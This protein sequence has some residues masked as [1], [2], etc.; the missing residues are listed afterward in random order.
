MPAPA[1]PL[2]LLFSF[3][4]GRGHLGPL[5]PLARTAT[6]AG[7]TTA[8]VGVRDV[9]LEQTAFTRLHPRDLPAFADSLAGR[10]GSGAGTRT[11]SG[12]RTGGTGTLLPVDPAKV[13]QRVAAIFLGE[14][15]EVARD[16]VAELLRQDRVD[17]LVCDGQDFG[18]MVAAERAGVPV[19][20]VDVL[21]TA[22]DEWVGSIRE[23][24]GRLRADSGL[25]PGSGL[26]RI[27]GDLAVV[28]FP[29]CLRATEDGDGPVVRMRPEPPEPGRDHPALAWLAAG[30][31]ERRVYVTLGTAFA[32]A[33]GDLLPRILAGLT[34]LPCRVLV[35]TGPGLDPAAVAVASERV[36]VERHVP[37]DGVLELVDLAVTH[38]GSGSVMGALARAVPVL[39]LPLG[40]DQLP[41][42]RRVA[43]LGCGALLDAATA[44]PADIGREASR[45][46]ASEAVRRSAERVRRECESLPPVDE[47]LRRIE[48]LA[49]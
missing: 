31:E 13:L 28:P 16:H 11:G 38:G 33:S 22:S 9:V 42:G 43:E 46:L 48:A 7:H 4:R 34:A 40:A 10:P 20:V 39:V 6:A 17:A 21:A 47:V 29:P 8:L 18:A 49:R 26:R 19:V 45:L 15:A 44:T 27:R 14:P 3:A 35:T 2:H 41:N 1:R 12:P 32:T 37:Q 5:L 25:P 36:R 23:P 30:S 24:L